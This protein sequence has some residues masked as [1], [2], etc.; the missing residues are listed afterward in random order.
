MGCLISGASWGTEPLGLE[1]ETQDF[2]HLIYTHAKTQD[3]FCL[4]GLVA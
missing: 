2:Y 4:L 3:F 1:M